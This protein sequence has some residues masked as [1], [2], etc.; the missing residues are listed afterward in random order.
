LSAEIWGSFETFFS[1]EA[2]KR[3]FMIGNGKFVAELSDE[4]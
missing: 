4:K 2:R 1:F 3:L